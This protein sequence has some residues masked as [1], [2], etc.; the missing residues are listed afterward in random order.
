MSPGR[1]NLKRSDKIQAS[2]ASPDSA[3]RAT[4]APS[5]PPVRN[6]D[7]MKSSWSVASGEQRT[8]GRL[9]RGR[10]LVA[11]EVP[12]SPGLTRVQHHRGSRR[13]G[14]RG[15]SGG[16]CAGG[17]GGLGG[18]RRQGR[19]LSW[20]LRRDPGRRCRRSR[21]PQQERRLPPAARPGGY[22]LMV[23]PRIGGSGLHQRL[24]HRGGDGQIGDGARTA[25]GLFNC[26]GQRSSAGHWS[27]LRPLPS[28]REG[29]RDWGR[30][31]KAAFLP[32]ASPMPW[33][34]GSP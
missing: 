20:E 31:R 24:D 28:L 10:E 12:Q 13:R 23:R 18:C 27:R 30:P 25:D 4:S 5:S 2:R 29:S 11:Q 32:P 8:R 33:A 6:L 1:T 15:G 34:S 16:G 7:Q 3:S 19:P 14:R 22:A 17:R 26:C 9:G 21:T